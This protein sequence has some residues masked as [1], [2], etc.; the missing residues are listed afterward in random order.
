MSAGLPLSA[1]PARAQGQG[2]EGEDGAATGEEEKAGYRSE[3]PDFDGPDSADP[4]SSEAQEEE[5]EDKL[6]AEEGEEETG[7]RGRLRRQ[8]LPT[9]GLAERHGDLYV[10]MSRAETTAKIAEVLHVRYEVLTEEGI[11]DLTRGLFLRKELQYRVVERVK[12]A[13]AESPEQAGTIGDL[14]SV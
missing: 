10:K 7:A 5:E 3:P 9:Q 13:F 4:S 1:P 8:G 11:M 6:P 12:N 2:E 14:V